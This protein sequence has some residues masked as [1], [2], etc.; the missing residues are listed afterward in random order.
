M[1]SVFVENKGAYCRLSVWRAGHSKTMCYAPKVKFCHTGA[2]MH[3]KTY[4]HLGL[5]RKRLRLSNNHISSIAFISDTS[6]QC[7][8]DHQSGHKV[9]HREFRLTSNVAN[10]CHWQP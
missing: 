1:V 9:D 3:D 7:L 8:D 2:T 4:R 6:Q 10:G 5:I